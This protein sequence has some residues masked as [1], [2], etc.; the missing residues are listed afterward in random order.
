MNN[1]LFKSDFPD[2]LNGCIKMHKKIFFTSAFI[3]M[4]LLRCETLEIDNYICGFR[5]LASTSN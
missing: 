3:L 5:R 2:W 1:L 4:H